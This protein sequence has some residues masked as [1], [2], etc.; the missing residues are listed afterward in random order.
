MRSYGDWDLRPS[1]R[2]LWVPTLI[3]HGEEDA[4]PMDMVAEWTLIPTSRLVKVPGAA[5]M[6]YAERP[7]VVWPEVA[8]FLKELPD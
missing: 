8:R 3:V 1:L 6:L 4:I 2:T 5:H 7:D